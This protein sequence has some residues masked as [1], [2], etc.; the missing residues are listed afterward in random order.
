MQYEKVWHRGDE[1]PQI[2]KDKTT[3]YEHP[4]FCLCVLWYDGWNGTLCEV[5]EDGNFIDVRNDKPYEDSF[6]DYWCY[7]DDICPIETDE[8]YLVDISV[9]EGH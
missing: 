1:K 4:T 7:T 5:T 2:Y 8:K 6:F 9:Q 3:G